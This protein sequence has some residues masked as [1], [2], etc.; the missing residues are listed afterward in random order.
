MINIDFFSTIWPLLTE[1][2]KGQFWLIL[3]LMGLSSLLEV[4]SLGAVLPFLGALVNPEI[5]FN[6]PSIGPIVRF[7]EL[8]SANQ[9]PLI[10]TT[11]FIVATVLSASVRLLLLYV[12]IKFSY[13]VGAD[14][15]IMIFRKTLYQD[16]SVHMSRNSSEVINGIITKTNTII[17]G[18]VKPIMT[19][20]SSSLFIVAI[21]TTLAFIDL[22][23]SMVAFFGFGGLYLMIVRQS[24]YRLIRNSKLI[25]HESNK[26]IK[27]LQEGMGGVRDVLIDGSQEYYCKLYRESDLLFRKATGDNMFISG[28]PRFIM[29]SLGMSIIA[30]LA[31][32]MSLGEDGL[33][34][35]I[36]T[37]GAFALGAQRL[38]PAFQQVYGAYS[39]IKG[40]QESF[41]DIEILLNQPIKSDF[42]T[43]SK[44][45]IKFEKEIKVKGLSFA[46]DGSNTHVLKDIN[47]SIPKGGHIGFIGKTGSG[48][49][50]LV[51]IIMGLLNP[52]DGG[53]YI[54]GELISQKNKN[55]WQKNIAHVPQNIYLSDNTIAENI[56][57]GLKPKDI[58]YNQVYAAAKKAQLIELIKD[59][60]DGYQTIVGECG[61]KLSGGQRQRIGIARALYKQANVLI[62]DEA[63][64]AL[65]NNTESEVMRSIEKLDDSL[66]VLIIA[67]RLT[68]LKGCNYVVKLDK[69]TIFDILEYKDIDND[70]NK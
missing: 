34:M 27:T 66:T 18:V 12:M 3:L 2:R 42:C 36:P 64:S 52:T 22:N 10:I 45:N 32:V 11:I 62:F 35:V 53:L 30:I 67:H 47:F 28:S 63:T 16:F 1:R 46:Y 43:E 6:N 57:F 65:D 7:F 50:T 61:I 24:K 13:A 4:V 29:E 15:S 5:L 41:K 25:A 39:N 59:L 60:P 19:I 14:L 40:S 23:T 48:K 31:Y 21:I 8:S 37:L 58:N 17:G 49:S 56:A 69:G 9:L 68:T 26:M 55:S 70:S 20:I 38:L 33:S 44:V 54:D 51:D